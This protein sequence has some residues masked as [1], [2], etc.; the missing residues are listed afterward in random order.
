[1]MTL[2]QMCDDEDEGGT[3]SEDPDAICADP[4]IMAIVACEDNP[5]LVSMMDPE[6]ME[7]IH[8]L[9][10]MCGSDG[11]AVHSDPG[12]AVCSAVD[13]IALCGDRDEIDSGDMS[14][15]ELTAMCATDCTQ[16]LADCID[17]PIFAENRDELVQIIDACVDPVEG[18]IGGNGI[19]EMVHLDNICNTEEE[20]NQDEGG[21]LAA[22]CATDCFAEMADCGD[23]LEM[24]EEER[25]QV[26]YPQLA[27]SI[28]IFCHDKYSQKVYM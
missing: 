24:S 27:T 19:C 4:C 21:D 16:E 13:V 2:G 12:D 14:D 15:A 6:E 18:A 7:S 23:E 17:N 10:T 9:G 20:E 5:L 8:L 11:M 1:M 26:N 25:G 28:S 22:M 3:E